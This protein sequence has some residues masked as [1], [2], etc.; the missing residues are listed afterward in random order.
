MNT[1]FTVEKTNLISIYIYEDRASLI[2]EKSDALP[3]MDEDM[4]ELADRALEKLR[5]MT[6]EEFAELDVFADE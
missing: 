4:R 1:G 6:D 5:A 3:Y 2:E